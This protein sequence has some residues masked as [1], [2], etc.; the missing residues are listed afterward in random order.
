L[1][2][3]TIELQDVTKLHRAEQLQLSSLLERF[4]HYV[5]VLDADDL[6]ILAIN[7]PYK[8]LLGSRDVKGLP[9]SDV[10]GGKNVNDLI[11][12]LRRAARDGH[13]HNTGP[14]FASVDGEHNPLGARFTHTIVP[15]TDVSG[16]EV[17]RLF[18][19]S[20]KAD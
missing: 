9:M 16:S 20:E 13:S 3:L 2:A 10:F 6:T 12:I 14:I 19:Y 17:S 4:P 18:V 15:I 8:Q 1:S 5:M 11:K 7:P